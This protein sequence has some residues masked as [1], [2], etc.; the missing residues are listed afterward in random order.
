MSR[1]LVDRWVDL[2]RF[3]ADLIIPKHIY[4]D[5]DLARH[6]MSCSLSMGVVCWLVLGD[7]LVDL[8]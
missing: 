1:L 8:V 7:R 2:D 3:Q 5:M 4:H 6:F